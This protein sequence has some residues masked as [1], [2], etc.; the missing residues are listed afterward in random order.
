MDSDP[1]PTPGPALDPSVFVSD[2]QDDNNKKIV[3]V[4]LLIF[5]A[6]CAVNHFSKI[7]SHKETQNSRN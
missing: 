2:L 6:T 4:F 5:E 1:D 7:K 3:Y